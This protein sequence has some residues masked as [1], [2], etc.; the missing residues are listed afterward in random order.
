MAEYIKNAAGL[1]VRQWP[2]RNGYRRETPDDMIRR[3]VREA[4]SKSELAGGT[5]VPTLTYQERKEALI[6]A[7]RNLSDHQRPP[8]SVDDGWC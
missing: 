7:I 8:S 6:K 5:F 2:N 1:P 4:R 3:K